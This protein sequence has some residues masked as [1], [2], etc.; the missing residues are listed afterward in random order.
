M[1]EALIVDDESWTR[2]MIKRFGNWEDY[3]IHIAGEAEDGLDAVRLIEQIHPQLII[4]DMNMPG[5]DGVALLKYVNEHHPNIKV[6]V[7][8]GHDDFVYMKHAIRYKVNEYLLK[9]IDATE[10]NQALA[11][12]QTDLARLT[13]SSSIPPIHFNDQ[14]L[15]LIRDAQRVIA[16]HI[17]EMNEDG[18]TRTFQ[19]LAESLHSLADDHVHQ[20][21]SFAQDWIFYLQEL[22][23]AQLSAEEGTVWMIEDHE[24]QS[25]LEQA[26]V[27]VSPATL[28]E[29]IAEQYVQAV[30]L[31]IH[32]RKF[33][34]KLN[35]DEIRAYIDRHFAD[36]L[37]LDRLARTFFVSKE[38]LSKA[39]KQEFGQTLTDYIQSVRMQKARCWIL[40]GIPIRVVAEMCGYDELG[41][42]YRVFKKQ[43][44]I[45]PGELRKG[46]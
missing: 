31:L 33:R 14:M 12:C 29:S 8:S 35:L 7:V 45:A 6:I 44:G 42:F 17:Q 43:F 5:A 9:P 36:A 13:T 27:V 24:V 28:L 46:Q 16:A 38:Y 3:N 11:K 15:R 22:M 26:A 10:L 34:T 1:I 20:W 40:E 21:S 23:S 30:R 18:I 41:Y 39:F 2:D 25:I 19:E 37:T 4:T 32:H